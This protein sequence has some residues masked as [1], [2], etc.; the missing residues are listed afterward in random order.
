[1]NTAVLIALAVFA[2]LAAWLALEPGGARPFANLD[3]KSQCFDPVLGSY[4]DANGQGREGIAKRSLRFGSKQS[5]HRRALLNATFAGAEEVLGQRGNANTP[6]RGQEIDMREKIMELEPDSSPLLIL[7][8]K[9][10]NEAAV[11]YKYSWWEDKLN[12]RFDAAGE[13]VT[14]EATKVKVGNSLM[15]GA[16]DL[17]YNTRTGEV[18]RV[19]GT[20]GEK[21]VMVRGVGSTAAIIKV[22]DE[23]LRIG[24]AAQQG[25]LDKPARSK[26]PVE[27]TNYTQIFRDPIDATNTRL[28]TKDRNKP[29]D[30]TR[31]VNK[32]GVEHAKDIEYAAMLGKPSDDKTGAQPRSTTGGFNHFANQNIT[33]AGGEITE[34]ELWASLEA[35]FRYGSST[36]LGLLGSKV[37]SIINK[38]PASKSIVTNPDPAKTFGINMVQLITPTGKR[39]NLVVHWLLEGKELAK[40]MWIVD[41]ANVGYRYLAGE[42]ENRDTHV[43]PNIQAPGQ[44]GR[45]D[46]YLTECGFL[47]GQSLTH[48][49]VVNI[50]S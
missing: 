23:F 12:V 21:I 32:T 40:Q 9:A 46:E 20:E 50:T 37:A 44:D 39:L 42:G 10:E 6:E 49:K 34:P 19:T 16:D 8:K 28:A 45:K 18:V 35:P 17:I 14:A 25:A 7:S 26:N 5:R 1:M 13:E 43:K 38:F 33:D 22:E 47:Y 29:R 24:S 41:L 3:E 36:K 4:L 48:G 31:Q 15:W 27:L 30:W 11:N 2:L